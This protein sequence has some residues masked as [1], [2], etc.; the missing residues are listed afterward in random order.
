[1]HSAELKGRECVK[2]KF[3]LHRIGDRDTNAI[4][5]CKS[6]DKGDRLRKAT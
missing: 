2:I 5:H 6:N 3:L 4:V 1:M